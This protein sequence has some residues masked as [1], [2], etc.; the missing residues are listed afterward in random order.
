[1]FKRA[2]KTIFYGEAPQLARWDEKKQHWRTDEI[3]DY[4]Y[5]EG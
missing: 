2:P 3:I 4:V 1:L 5:N